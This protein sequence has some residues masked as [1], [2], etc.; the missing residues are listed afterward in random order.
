MRVVLARLLRE[1]SRRFI[2]LS[3]ALA[4]W[5]ALIMLVVRNA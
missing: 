4:A 5:F 2:V 1:D 3:S